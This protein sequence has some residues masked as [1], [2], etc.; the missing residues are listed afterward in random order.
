MS[1][2]E[3]V[4][5]AIVAIVVVG[6]R[7]LPSMMRTAGVWLGRARR[8]LV[9]VRAQSGIDEILKAE[10]LHDE[11]AQFRALARGE[12]MSI[13][14]A[15]TAE[16]GP[17]PVAAPLAPA[18][19]VDRARE[20]PVEGCDAYGAPADDLDPYSPELFGGEVVAAP[21]PGSRA[22]EGAGTSP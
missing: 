9:D 16:A 20:W 18:P 11:I 3:L 17:S 19:S 5:C 1:F 12:L 10:G 13:E 6:P 15:I 8:L 14:A 21:A 7:N 4:L 22:R 2:G